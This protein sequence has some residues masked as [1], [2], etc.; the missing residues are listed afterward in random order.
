MPTTAL[1]PRPHDVAEKSVHEVLVD[2]WLERSRAKGL[3]RDSLMDLFEAAVL[4]LWSRTSTTLGEVTLTAIAERILLHAAE[5]YPAFASLTVEPD[6][7]VRALGL[8]ANADALNHLKLVEGM[9]AVLVEF[10]TVIGTLTADLMTDELHAEL[11]KVT[12]RQGAVD[13]PAK[14]RSAAGGRKEKSR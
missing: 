9:R 4:A 1:A 11:R 13:A 3:T 7:R 12:L 2:G 8:R 14:T 6:G 5:R 10:L